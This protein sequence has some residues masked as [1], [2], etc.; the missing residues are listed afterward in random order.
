MPFKELRRK[1]LSWPLPEPIVV[2]SLTIP[3]VLTYPLQGKT[4]QFPKKSS[5][6]VTF[7]SYKK[8]QQLFGRCLIVRR[9]KRHL[10]IVGCGPILA[11]NHC[12]KAVI[13]KAKSVVGGYKTLTPQ[14]LQQQQ[15]TFQRAEAYAN[16]NQQLNS[17]PKLSDKEIYSR[18]RF[19]KPTA[20]NITQSTFW[21]DY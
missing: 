12:W 14:E 20:P 11:S 3:I 16:P 6:E 15:Q 7:F 4:I 18:L 1:W 9:A 13:D 21:H 5:V 2:G 19:G 8:Q 10:F 17:G